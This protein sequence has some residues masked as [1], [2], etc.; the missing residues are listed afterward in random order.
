MKYAEETKCEVF[1]Y[2][3]DCVKK[4]LIS[5]SSI[6]HSWFLKIV[7]S[8]T[9]R[10]WNR[11]ITESLDKEYLITFSNSNWCIVNKCRCQQSSSNIEEDKIRIIRTEAK[12]M[13][14][15]IKIVKTNKG[16]NDVF[17][18]LS[19]YEETLGFVLVSL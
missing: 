18:S 16:W 11:I 2:L 4:A 9:L 19:S 15:D 7:T 10:K 3:V 13:Y 17:S 1:F 5:W 8:W 12:W 14:T 6:L